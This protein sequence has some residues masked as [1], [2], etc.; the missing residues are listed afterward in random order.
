MKIQNAFRLGLFGG[1]GVLV[2]VVIGAA[3]GN[4]ATILTYVGAALF[5]AL[6]VDPAVSF[7]ERHGFKRGLAILTV[8]I[9]IL[10]VF[11]GLILA[12]IPVLADQINK[13]I[14]SAPDVVDAFESGAVRHRQSAAGCL[15]IAGADPAAR[16]TSRPASCNSSVNCAAVW[17]PPITSTRPSGRE[18]GER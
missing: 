12:I 8:L 18:S 13:L 5:L 6:G 14:E 10:A 9:G 2:A 11:T 3:V 15:G 17:P 7:L 4:L 1:L 16:V